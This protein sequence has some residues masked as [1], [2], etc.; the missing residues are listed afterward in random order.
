MLRYVDLF[1]WNIFYKELIILVFL[2][3]NFNLFLVDVGK[4]FF[5]NEC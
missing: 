3:R 2:K 1:I 5:I 4:F